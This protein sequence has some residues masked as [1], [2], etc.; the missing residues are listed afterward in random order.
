MSGFERYKNFMTE[1][2]GGMSGYMPDVGK[3][4]EST[5]SGDTKKLS[6]Q[7]FTN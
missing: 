2:F 5:I 4:A 6:T 1:S 7:F 3:F